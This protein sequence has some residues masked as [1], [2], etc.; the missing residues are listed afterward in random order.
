MI[1]TLKYLKWIS[2]FLIL[3]SEARAEL[4]YKLL[5]YV[6]DIL[7]VQSY[8]LKLIRINLLKFTEK[9]KYC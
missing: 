6:S 9:Y 1:W 4:I 3:T 2:K 5:L 8:N 7:S